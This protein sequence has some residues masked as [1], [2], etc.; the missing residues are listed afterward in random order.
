MRRCSANPRSLTLSCAPTMSLQYPRQCNPTD[1]GICH[2]GSIPC[3]RRDVRGRN[4][5]KFENDKK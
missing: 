1:A 5:G 4:G 3:E 2:L